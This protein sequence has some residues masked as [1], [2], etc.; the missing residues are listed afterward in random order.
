MQLENF[1]KKMERDMKE[2]SLK[3][4]LSAASA[5]S[6]LLCTELVPEDEATDSLGMAA[7]ALSDAGSPLQV[8]YFA[9]DFTVDQCRPI[10]LGA[11][12][13]IRRFADAQDGLVKAMIDDA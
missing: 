9:K 10:I 1:M 5:L 13:A 2:E 3:D 7:E 4:A 8:R 12:G 11:I 6:I